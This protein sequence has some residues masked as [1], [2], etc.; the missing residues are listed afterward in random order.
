M[1]DPDRPSAA[2]LEVGEP[3]VGPS[4][5]SVAAWATLV[6]GGLLMLVGSFEPWTYSGLYRDALVVHRNAFELGVWNSF[7]PA[8]IPAVALGGAS[9]LEGAWL[10]AGRRLPRALRLPGAFIGVVG[11]ATGLYGLGEARWYTNQI[12]AAYPTIFYAGAAYGVW[13]VL[14]GGVGILAVSASQ[15]PVSR[16][17]S[18]GFALTTVVVLVGC[19]LLLAPRL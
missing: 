6:L 5:L 18:F 14:A 11:V 13:L 2:L 19:G 3:E 8:G 12:V 10:L 1:D 9:V 16:R 7:S 15:I 4:P 17:A